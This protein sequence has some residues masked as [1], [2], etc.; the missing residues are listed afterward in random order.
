MRKPKALSREVNLIVMLILIPLTI[1]ISE[2]I[3][4]E[5]SIDSTIIDSTSLGEFIEWY[6]V[7]CNTP[8]VTIWATSKTNAEYAVEAESLTVIDGVL[9]ECANQAN[10]PHNGGVQKEG[11]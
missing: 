10:W 2:G 8:G 3:A 4:E 11:E 7:E 9:I 6:K 5:I 1:G